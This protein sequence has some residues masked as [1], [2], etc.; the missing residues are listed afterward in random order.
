M[1]GNVTGTIPVDVNY[2]DNVGVVST[3]LHI[4]GQM[5]ITDNLSPFAFSWDTTLHPDGDYTLTAYAFDAAG[6][7]ASSANILVAIS[8]NATTDTEVPTITIASPIDGEV[9]GTTPVNVNYSDN[10]DV[11]R[12]E[13]YVNGQKI[14][15]DSQA[16]FAF[17]W[18][19]KALP[20]GTYTLTS[21]AFDEA[22]NEGISSAIL[23]SVNNTPAEDTDTTAPVITSF[24]LIEGMKVRRRQ[25]VSVL[26]TDDRTVAKITLIINGA[27][28]ATSQSSALS[29]KWRIRSQRNFTNAIHNVTVQVSDQAN[30]MTAKTVTEH[31]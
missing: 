9:S 2:S 18:D 20:D 25:T 26:A 30:N 14:M 16:P 3:E 24:N 12:V 7:Q 28:V 17:S 23:V 11:V 4:N 15:T 8:N 22:G 31:N 5:I 27:E 10:I 29:Y 21:K 1:N 13:L 19:T 6:N